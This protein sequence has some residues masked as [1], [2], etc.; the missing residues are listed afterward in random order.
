MPLLRYCRKIVLTIISF[1]FVSLS[2]FARAEWVIHYMPS[3]DPNDH[4]LDYIFALINLSLEKQ[5]PAITEVQFKPLPSVVSFARAVHELKQDAY[6][7]YF[8]SGGDNIEKLGTENLMAVDFPVD[9]GLLSYRICFVSARAR[10][11]VKQAEA[12]EDLRRFSIAQ[13]KDWPDVR[14]LRN[15]GFRVLE[16]PIYNSLFKMVLAGRVDMVCRGINELREELHSQK[17]LGPLQYDESFVLVYFMPYKLYFNKSSAELVAK[18]EAGLKI[19]NQDGSLQELFNHH[20][21]DDIDF[22]QLDKRKKFYLKSGYENT[23]S[24]IYKSYFFYPIDAKNTD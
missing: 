1:L 11:K 19:A 5:T 12:L 6:P 22:A 23:F 17:H 16:V 20:F 3:D 13:G 24:E 9:H 2:A 4:R 21:K 7:N 15:N 14:I 8:T 18:I 10:E